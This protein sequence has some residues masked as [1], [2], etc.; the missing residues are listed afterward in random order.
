MSNLSNAASESIKDARDAIRESGAAA[1][2]AAP[3]IAADLKA[4]REDVG[5]LAA[6]ISEIFAAKG[7]NVWQRT[8]ASVDDALADVQGAKAEAIDAVRDVGDNLLG[9]IDDS[10]EQRPYTTLAL[11]FGIGFLLG[12]MGRR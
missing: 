4:L 9:A 7:G 5:R 12:G 11:A 2:A 6:Q 10:L 3:D 1:S 8:R